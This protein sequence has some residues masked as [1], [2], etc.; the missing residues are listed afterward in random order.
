MSEIGEESKEDKSKSM[1]ELS[2]QSYKKSRNDQ[3]EQKYQNKIRRQLEALR[4]GDKSIYTIYKPPDDSKI[5]EQNKQVL[6]ILKLHPDD[7]DI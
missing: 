7:E 6:N 2:V 1:I 5:A 4:R 3:E